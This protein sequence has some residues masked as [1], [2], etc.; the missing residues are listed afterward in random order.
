MKLNLV[1][2]LFVHS[3]N[4]TGCLRGV[5]AFFIPIFT[6]TSFSYCYFPQ[7][8]S[9]YCACF[10]LSQTVICLLLSRHKMLG[11]KSGFLYYCGY[12]WHCLYTIYDVIV[13]LLF[14]KSMPTLVVVCALD[15]AGCL[16]EGVWPPPVSNSAIIVMLLLLSASVPSVP[17][18][19]TAPWWLI[20]QWSW[21]KLGVYLYLLV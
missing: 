17:V 11:D 4:P 3:G 20:V 10:P 12:V 15:C 1:F 18:P 7:E 16:L 8:I 2:W 13:D 19:G 6:F 14:W 21:I 5:Y 9:I